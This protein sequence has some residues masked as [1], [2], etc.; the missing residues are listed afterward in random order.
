MDLIGGYLLIILLLFAGNLALL[1]GNYKISNVKLAVLSAISFVLSFVLIYLLAYLN[2]SLMLLL[3]YLSYIFLL[4]AVL[5]FAVMW[6]YVKNKLQLNH[7]IYLIS[8]IAVVSAVLLSSQS[9]LTLFDSIVYSLFVFIVLFFVYQ[10]TKLLVH[11]KRSYSVI[12]SEFMCLFSILMF[13][14]ALTY[15]SA[16]QLNYTMFSSFLI[17]TPTYQLIYVGIGICVVLILGFVLNDS[18]GGNS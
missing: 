4:V 17:L 9:N 11:A 7:S 6:G 14:F 15:N 5:I 12:V 2:I 16:R 3:D 1:L 18:K 8:I 13:I 10:L